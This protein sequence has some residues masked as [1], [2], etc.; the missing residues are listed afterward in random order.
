MA[1]M[2]SEVYDA[3]RELGVSEE[4]ARRAAEAG[5]GSGAAADGNRNSAK[6][7]R[8]P[9]HRSRSP[10]Q[11]HAM[12]DRHRSPAADRYPCEG[13]CPLNRYSHSRSRPRLQNCDGWLIFNP[14]KSRA[15]GA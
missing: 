3:L 13:I 14:R 1:V 7:Y 9:P 15:E 4:E 12:A 6:H 2:I 11:F 5:G 10:A 8:C